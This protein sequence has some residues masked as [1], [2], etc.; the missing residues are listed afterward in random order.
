MYAAERLEHDVRSITRNWSRPAFYLKATSPTSSS[1][2]TS[3]SLRSSCTRGARALLALA[4][5][6]GPD[7]R[8]AHRLRGARRP[9]LLERVP[10]HKRL[11]NAPADAACRSATCPASSS[12]T[13][14]WT[15]ST[16]SPSTGCRRA[17]TAATST[18]STCCTNRPSGSMTRWR[19]IARLPAAR[20]GCAAEPAQDHPAAV[21]RGIDFV[22]QVVKPWRRI[23][24]RRTVPRMLARW[25]RC[26][27]PT[28][29]TANSYLGL[30]RQA[31]H[32]HQPR[33][34][35]RSPRRAQARARRR[36]RHD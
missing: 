23:T 27:P 1:A 3:P 28:W 24:R 26:P 22:G 20:L 7:A 33:P 17:T 35:A 11:V 10:P 6:H 8:P 29:A 9:R 2:S 4:G 25:K 15:R 31:S 19:D 21:E 14:T 36:R 32:S 18:T 16:S 12:R 30:V 5:G 13:C 34:G